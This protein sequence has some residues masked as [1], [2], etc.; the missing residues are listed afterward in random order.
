MTTF[1]SKPN[2]DAPEKKMSRFFHSEK[3]IRGFLE[4]AGFYIES[5][6]AYDEKLFDDFNRSVTVDHVDSLVEIVAIKK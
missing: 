5:T 4:G 3:S 6:A 2:K 1:I